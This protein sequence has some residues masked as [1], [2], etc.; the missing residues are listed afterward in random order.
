MMRTLLC[1][2]LVAGTLAGC[3]VVD[4]VTTAGDSQAVHE[5][6]MTRRYTTCVKLQLGTFGSF[7]SPES[8]RRAAE[9]C[10]GVITSPAT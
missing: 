9:T 3:K 8:R 7:A 2:A 4:R 10:Q 6:E 5:R 1:V